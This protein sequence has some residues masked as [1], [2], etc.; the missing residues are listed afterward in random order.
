MK[1]LKV[2]LF[3]ELSIQKSEISSDIY[4]SH[5]L[6]LIKKKFG[7]TIYSDLN[8]QIQKWIKSKD[9]YQEKEKIYL[10]TKG[11]YISDSIC[12]DLFIVD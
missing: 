10:T 5:D 6:I 3:W 11:K 4:E 9:V 7:H 8:K 1:D 12:C 2:H